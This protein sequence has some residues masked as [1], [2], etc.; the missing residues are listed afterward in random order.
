MKS[1]FWT[2]AKALAVG[3][4]TASPV[5]E[6]Q[7]SCDRPTTKLSLGRKSNFSS[8]LGISPLFSQFINFDDHVQDFVLE[9]K[10]L[11]IP[12][13][14]DAFNPSIVR[15]Q[16]AILMCFR[17]R[18]RETRLTNKMGLVYLDEDFNLIS[19]P[20][21]LQIPPH[22]SPLMSREQ[23][24]RL[25]AIGEKLFIVYNNYFD[26]A[27]NAEIRRMYSAEIQNDED[28]FYIERADG[29]FVYQG[30][31]KERREK[32]WVPFVYQGNLLLARTL[33]PHQVLQPILGTEACKTIAITS[34]T[35]DWPWGE[36]RGGTPALRE[37]SEY[38]AFFHSCTN[39]K[40]AHSQGKE[41]LH[42]FMGAYT[43][44]AQPPFA[45]TR[46]SE[47]PIFAQG[48]YEGYAYKTWKPLRVVF[49]AGFI[50][51]DQYI[52]ISYGKQDHEIWLVK[53]DK[54]RLLKSL[55][56]VHSH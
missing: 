31:Q 43:F 53:L 54:K 23:D 1:W 36:L 40:T 35:L 56:P 9:T 21:I 45:L 33:F 24:P 20:T 46:M 13:Y 44:S 48:F 15:W 12:G 37:G 55:K 22:P 50:A 39:L 7:A 29:L 4:I 38:L 8:C 32:N 18:D 19:L 5:L 2:E 10:R 28:G 11:E 3:A 47:K 52:W 49:P 51:D 16:G 26:G 25:I 27:V 14:P 17:I 34:N 30:E 6:I 41:M 42:Y